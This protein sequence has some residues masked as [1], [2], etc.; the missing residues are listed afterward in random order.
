[1]R[2]AF[3]TLISC[4]HLIASPALAVQPVNPDGSV[5]GVKPGL[6]TGKGQLLSRA[7]LV[8]DFDFIS[9]RELRGGII[10]AKTK[11]AF[12][13]FIL[14]KAEANLKIVPLADGR[15]FQM[16]DL[17]TSQVVGA[18]VCGISEC[19]FTARVMSGKLQLTETWRATDSGFEVREASQDFSGLPAD[20]SGVFQR[21]R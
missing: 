2:F 4:L 9:V 5:F 3:V 20:Y 1:M 18:G 8:P 13:G 21:A 6:F 12:H 14:A 11:A 16:L 10:R 7:A 17:D 15:S 19:K